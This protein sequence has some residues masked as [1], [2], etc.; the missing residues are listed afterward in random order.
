MQNGQLKKNDQLMSVNG[1]SLLHLS[2][3]DALDALKKALSE[4]QPLDST[5]QL[6]RYCHSS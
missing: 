2:N 4:A 3:K 1:Q 6:V 5:I